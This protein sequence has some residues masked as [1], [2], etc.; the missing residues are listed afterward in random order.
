MY[1]IVYVCLLYWHINLKWVYYFICHSETNNINTGP[2]VKE[3]P[4]KIIMIILVVKRRV[5]IM[6]RVIHW[7]WFILSIWYIT[8]QNQNRQT[9]KHALIIIATN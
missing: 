2:Y 9:V 8:T 6:I 1:S 3:L 7:L 5:L 4:N